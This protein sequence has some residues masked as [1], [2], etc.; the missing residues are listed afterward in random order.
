MQKPDGW[1]G[2]EYGSVLTRDEMSVARALAQVT[3]L[4]ISN[5]DAQ[6]MTELLRQ[7]GWQRPASGTREG[8]G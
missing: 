2:V 1:Y 5:S 6:Y 7:A 4:H 3:E 8:T